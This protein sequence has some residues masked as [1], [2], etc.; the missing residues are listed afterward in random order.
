M[1]HNCILWDLKRITSI[2]QLYFDFIGFQI[3]ELRFRVSNL[4][5]EFRFKCLSFDLDFRYQVS[6][7]IL[8]LDLRLQFP[9]SS[10][11]LYS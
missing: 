3:F 1:T 2:S 10:V 7:Y 4:D 5:F 6:I 8:N 11:V 9:T